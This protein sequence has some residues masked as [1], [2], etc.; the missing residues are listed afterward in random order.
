M[1]PDTLEE[2]ARDRSMTRMREAASERALASH[3]RN[4]AR[5]T[6]A[7]RLRRLADRLEPASYETPCLN[8]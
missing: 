3:P 8:C 2:I 6:V 1:T 7:A 4:R 5:H